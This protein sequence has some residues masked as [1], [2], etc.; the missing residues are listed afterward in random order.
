MQI[1]VGEVRSTYAVQGVKVFEVTFIFSFR[2]RRK[3]LWKDLEEKRNSRKN[4]M[5]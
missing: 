5:C 4:I 2:M 1:R 3:L